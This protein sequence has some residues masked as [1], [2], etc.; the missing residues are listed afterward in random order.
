SIKNLT[1]NND[2]TIAANVWGQTLTITPG[3]NP[4]TG[5]VNPLNNSASGIIELE[6]GGNLTIDGT[7]SNIFIPMNLNNAG[8]IQVASASTL[9]FA[10]DNSAFNLN[11]QGS[12]ILSGGMVTGADGSQTLENAA[13]HTISG[14]GTIQNLTLWN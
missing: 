4:Y 8:L 3:V 11:G 7:G 6:N 10:G 14:Y 5:L 13:G 12:L 9:T 2:G 1:L